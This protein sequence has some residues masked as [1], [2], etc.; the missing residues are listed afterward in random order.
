MSY[1][2]YN[3]KQRPNGLAKVPAWLPPSGMETL[4]QRYD[5]YV[6]CM[7]DTSVGS[8]GNYIKDFDEWLNS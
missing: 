7:Q 8:R 1:I 3:P 2:E 4:K 6:Q 5:I